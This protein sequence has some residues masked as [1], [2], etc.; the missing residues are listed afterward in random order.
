METAVLFGYS[1]SSRKCFTQ[2]ISPKTA[3]LNP[4]EICTGV[5]KNAYDTMCLLDIRGSQYIFGQRVSDNGWFIQSFLPT[6]GGALG[7][8]TATGRWN[9]FYD[10]LIPL[11][12]QDRTFLFGH[13]ASGDYRWFIQEVMADGTLS[14]CENDSGNWHNPFR[15]ICSYNIN[16]RC[17]I[18]GQSQNKNHWFIQEVTADGKLCPSETA[19]GNWRNFFD[20]LLPVKI[21]NRTFLF[22]H[23]AGGDCKWFLQEIMQ[24]G[25]LSSSE[26]ASGCWKWGYP[27]MCSFSLNDKCYLFGQSPTDHHWFIQEVTPDGNLYPVE[28]DQGNWENFFNHMFSFYD[29]LSLDKS[30]WMYSLFNN[31]GLTLK[32]IVIPGTH[33]AGMYL[34]GFSTLG[35]TQDQNISQQLLGGVRYF[36]LRPFY[37]RNRL[38]QPDVYVYDPRIFISHEGILGPNIDDVFDDIDRFMSSG[39]KEIILLKISHYRGDFKNHAQEGFDLLKKKILE[40]LGRWLLTDKPAQRICDTPLEKLFGKVILLIDDDSATENNTPGIREGDGIYR[41]KNFNDAYPSNGSVTVYDDYS[42]TTD[43]STMRN[44]Q[45]NKFNNFEGTCTAD[46]HVVCDLFLLSWTLT[47]ITDVWHY[48]KI[49]NEKLMN[50]MVSIGYNKYHKIPNILYVDYYQYSSVTNICIYLNR[51]FHSL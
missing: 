38:V 28:T 39:S 49:A 37:S 21:K 13:K 16:D 32:D 3:R 8:E 33:D 15:T 11:Q 45:I 20:V 14:P 25:I 2:S 34:G 42:N 29:D 43:Y 24:N 23:K 51:K 30:K 48:A 1:N 44:D 26:S 10:V 7:V 47:P 27:T 22:G 41:Y 5:W 36:D 50:E 35:K 31:K 18:L 46:L 17:Y 40:K 9:N 12:I 19:S 4:D 6:S